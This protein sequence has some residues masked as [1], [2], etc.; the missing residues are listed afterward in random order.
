MSGA[1]LGAWVDSICQEL[2]LAEVSAWLPWNKREEHSRLKESAKE[3]GAAGLFLVGWGIHPHAPEVLCV[4]E[5]PSL[6]T[7]LRN[8][9]D[10]VKWGIEH[11]FSLLRE[12]LEE[13]G[14][15]RTMTQVRV[16]II[17]VE[18]EALFESAILTHQR[19]NALGSKRRQLETIFLAEHFRRLGYK[20]PGNRNFRGLHLQELARDSQSAATPS[21][22][23]GAAA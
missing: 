23:A 16:R 10:N 22:A 4:G 18:E 6:R 9:E 21:P 17:P 7:R 14:D 20:V 2:Q 5:A 13:R 19:R 11:G 15:H 12:L 3:A 1:E 8:L